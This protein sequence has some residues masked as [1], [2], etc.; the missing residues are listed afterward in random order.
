[1]S[2]FATIDYVLRDRVAVVTLNRP[3]RL[4]ALN[5]QIFIDATAAID[6]ALAEGARALVITGAG[7]AFCSGA[8]LQDP[9]IDPTDLGVT[10]DRSYNPFARKLAALDIPVITAINGLAAGA[11]C[12]LALMG[13]ISVMA[14]SAY[15]LLAFVNIGLVPDAGATWLVA[16]GAGRTKALEMALLGER[17]SAEEARAVGLVTRVVDE[18][19]VLDEAMAIARKLASGPSIAIGLIRKQVAAA[20]TT[21]FD[22]TL[23]LER[24]NQRRAGRTADFREAVIAFMEKRAPLFKGQ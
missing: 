12:G 23:D 6:Q 11:G 18:E 10:I 21:S 24:E 3:D 14:R 15:L 17:L 13:D 1:L 2:A 8:D 16:K 9:S 20:L 4:N 5:A 19:A 22:E 7:R